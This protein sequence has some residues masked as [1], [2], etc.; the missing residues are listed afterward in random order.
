MAKILSV[1]K[2]IGIERQIL[3]GLII[4]T[5]FYHNISHAIKTDYFQSSQHRLIADWLLDYC[6]NYQK[7]PKN[8]IKSI[9]DIEKKKLDTDTSQIIE[10]ILNKIGY[11]F[12]DESTFNNDYV[13]KNGIEYFKKR[14]L[15]ITCNQILAL[16]DRNQITEA[17]KI[18]YE[19]APIEYNDGGVFTFSHEALEEIANREAFKQETFSYNGYMGNVVGQIERGQF[20]AFLG[21]PKTGKTWWLIETAAQALMSDLKVIFVS[22]E[23]NRMAIN[24]RIYQ[25]FNSLIQPSLF[26]GDKV[27]N[28]PVLDCMKNQNDTCYEKYRTNTVSLFNNSG[29]KNEFGEHGD[30]M[31]CS[32]CYENLPK[33]FQITTWFETI[34]RP[35]LNMQTRYQAIKNFKPLKNK[36]KTYFF[37]RS[38]LSIEEITDRIEIA[39]YRENFR[40]DLVIVDYLDITKGIEDRHDINRIWEFFDGYTTGKNIIG[41]TVSQAGRQ[42]K[43]KKNIGISD[44][45]EEWRKVAHVN[46]FIGI[47]Q[48]VDEKRKKVLRTGLLANRED[49]FDEYHQALVLQNL[50]AG[51][52]CLDSF[53]YIS[54]EETETN[55]KK[56]KEQ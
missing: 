55:T 3:L 1:E 2:E 26:L 54:P 7:A 45:S 35:E 40:A 20:I 32:Y 25:R 51:Q 52:V 47:H 44:I 48:T 17:E 14:N 46:K 12:E 8:K 43:N 41:F 28:F 11:E 34:Q 27:H 49:D 38:S 33:E 22:M 15:E 56:K 31:P 24:D 6:K 4:S 37:P 29:V 16:I 13:L 42:T 19:I 53:K 36:L 23:M 9:F 18:R 39:E 5:K 10:N 21:G 50:S 30:Y